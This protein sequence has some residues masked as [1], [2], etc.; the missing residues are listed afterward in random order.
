MKIAAIIIM[1]LSMLITFQNAVRDSS[2]LGW[3]SRFWAGLIF[4]GAEGFVIFYI[5]TAT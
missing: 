5:V 3:I 4:L 2:K 1:V